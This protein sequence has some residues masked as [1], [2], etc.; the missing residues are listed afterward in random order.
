MPGDIIGIEHHQLMLKPKPT[1]ATK[2]HITIRSVA[3][4]EAHTSV[5]AQA[6]DYMSP[7]RR[8]LFLHDRLR[9]V[10]KGQPFEVVSQTRA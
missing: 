4:E 8:V 1:T 10:T 5:D 6:W 3:G 2:V 7:A 9:K